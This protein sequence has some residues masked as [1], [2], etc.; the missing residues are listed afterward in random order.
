MT[1]NVVKMFALS[2][3][4]LS[5]AAAPVI[6]QNADPEPLSIARQGYLFAGGKYSTVNDRRVMTGHLY[7]EFQIPSRQTHPWPI[8]MIHGGASPEPTSLAHP[9]A[10]RAGPSSFCDRVMRCT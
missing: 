5:A 7:A 10:G 4:F 1:W 8:V 9:T 2:A 3:A 6:A